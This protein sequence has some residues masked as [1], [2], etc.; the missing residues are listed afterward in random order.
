MCMHAQEEHAVYFQEK[1]DI[2]T[3]K[4]YLFFVRVFSH[5]SLIQTRIL[6][7]YYRNQ[8]S[9]LNDIERI[10]NNA[11]SFNKEDSEICKSSQIITQVLKEI[12]NN[13]MKKDEEVLPLIFF[14]QKKKYNNFLKNPPL[15]IN[16]YSKNENKN[17]Y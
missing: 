10:K 7:G 1:V 9:I 11:Y 6:N 13:F 12:V 4:E 16:N 17:N 8:L 5:I 15:I 3:Y 14:N 2:R